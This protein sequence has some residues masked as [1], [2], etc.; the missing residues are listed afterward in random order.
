MWSQLRDISIRVDEDA[1]RGTP[2][3]VS[4]Y[5]A[6]DDVHATAN[7]EK[8]ESIRVTK[9]TQQGFNENG[10]AQ[11]SFGALVSHQ[12]ATWISK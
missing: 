5:Y 10:R 11:R 2:L 1:E 3:N 7:Q 12:M 9:G 8:G 4:Q 6:L